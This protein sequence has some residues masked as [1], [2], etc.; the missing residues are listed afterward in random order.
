M[1]AREG[2]GGACETKTYLA[3]ERA[4]AQ[5]SQRELES[6][7]A[8]VDIDLQGDQRIRVGGWRRRHVGWGRGVGGR[9]ARDARRAVT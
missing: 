4:G 1:Q 9:A 8:S 6:F 7:I 5:V 3:W 2:G